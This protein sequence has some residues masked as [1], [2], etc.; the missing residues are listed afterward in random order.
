M[1]CVLGLLRAFAWKARREEG[2]NRKDTL[3]EVRPTSSRNQVAMRAGSNFP[4]Y[5]RRF[6][7]DDGTQPCCMSVAEGQMLGLVSMT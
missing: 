4:V 7:L 2:L 6:I 5:R 3:W 1:Y